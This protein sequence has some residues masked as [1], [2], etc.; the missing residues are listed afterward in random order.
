MLPRYVLILACWIAVPT[1]AMPA[2]AQDL[3]PT[4]PSDSTEGVTSLDVR[5]LRAVYASPPAVASVWRVAD[6]TSYKVFMGAPVVTSIAAAAGT[7]EPAFAYRL[8]VAEGAAL[9]SYYTLKN[10]FQRARP[11]RVVP[12]IASRRASGTEELEAVFDPYSFPSGH[13]AVAF[14]VATTYALEAQ[15][16][17]VTVPALVWASSVAVSRMWLGVHY[18]TDVLA[19]SLLGAGIG[20]TVHALGDVITPGALE[21]GPADPSAQVPVVTVRIP[22]R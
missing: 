3:L 18:P 12:G 15:Q 19:G 1:A 7:V 5:V 14:A 2:A 4:A 6:W 11:Y 13:A 20:L 21:D 16:A 8:I 17:A 10:L 22:L 9:V